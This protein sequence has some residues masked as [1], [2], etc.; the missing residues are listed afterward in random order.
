MRRRRVQCCFMRT[1]MR[2]PQTSE[3]GAWLPRRDITVLLLSDAAELQGA[4]GR[5]CAAA[6]VELVIAG[7]LEQMAG[8][9]GDVAAVLVDAGAGSPQLEL[10][11]WKGPTVVVGFAQ[12]GSR[13]W[14]RAEQQRAD[15]VAVLPD[16]APWLANYLGRLRNSSPGAAVVGVMGASGGAG[17]STLAVLLAAEAAARGTRTL[18]V[19]GDQWGGGLNAA[20]SAQHLPGL[21]WPDLLRASGAIN[22]EQLAASLPQLGALAMLSWNS[23]PQPDVPAQTPAAVGEVLRAARAAYGLVVVDLACNPSAVAALAAHCQGLALVVPARARAAAAA[24]ALVPA[25]PPMPLA[26][27]VRGPLGEGLDAA[28]VADAVELALAGQFPQLRGVARALEAQRPADLL[29]R[30]AVR[31]LLSGLLQ[32]VAG[33]PAAGAPGAASPAARHGRRRP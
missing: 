31:T 8:R 29:R 16:S 32:W 21:R 18:L 1:R 23:A 3:P 12:D 20:L 11:G 6:A 17:A 33:E 10:T 24:L 15:R 25:L 5:V 4:V 14:Q 7:S 22:P 30:R 28:M 19:D 27:V 2:H 9:W 13:V 26:A